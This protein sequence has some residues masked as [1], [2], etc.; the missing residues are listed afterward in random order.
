[1]NG[2]TGRFKEARLRI[3]L[4]IGL[5]GLLAIPASAQRGHGKRDQSEGKQQQTA[6]Q[7]KKTREAEEAYKAALGK[8]P[9]QKPPDPW[10]NV[11]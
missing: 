7:R 9:D 4:I 2:V 6:E 3:A 1:M 11:R 5:V 8:I 10:K